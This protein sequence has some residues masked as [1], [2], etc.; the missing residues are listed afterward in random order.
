[1]EGPYIISAESQDFIDKTFY[2]KDQYEGFD[3][4]TKHYILRQTLK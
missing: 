1:M 2:I 3:V 4:W